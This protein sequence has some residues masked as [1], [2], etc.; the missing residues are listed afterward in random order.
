MIS[1]DWIQSYSGKGVTPL[2]LSV[3]QVSLPDIS[4]ALAQK[5]RFT[6]H[7]REMGYSVAQH[8]AMGACE[9]PT[10]VQKLAFLLHEVSE[11]YLPDVATPLKRHIKVRVS[12]SRRLISWR[13]LEARHADV[14]FAAL[15]LS[16]IRP[17]IDSEEAREIDLRMLMT[18]RRDL[19]GV[20]PAPW[21][22]A[23]RPFQ[24][25]IHRVWAPAYAEH[26]FNALYDLYLR[27]YRA[28]VR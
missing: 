16:E 28:S 22:I 12:G 24:W 4:H 17:L 1:R 14:V 7:L 19:M 23:T 18:E 8:C 5:V 2:D 6:W 25:R 27:G 26:D 15:G 20:S 13:E 3:E 10:A 21:G 11:V 9:C